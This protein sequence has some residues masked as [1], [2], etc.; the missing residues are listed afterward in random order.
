[1]ID[2]SKHRLNKRKLYIKLQT[3]SLHSKDV[4]SCVSSFKCNAVQTKFNGILFT[5]LEVQIHRG[6]SVEVLTVEDVEKGDPNLYQ[7]PKCTI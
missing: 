3:F 6:S 2:I 7:T 4:A 1:M 5:K